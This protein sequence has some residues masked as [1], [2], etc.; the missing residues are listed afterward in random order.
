MAPINQG[1]TVADVDA[2]VEREMRCDA[3]GPAPDLD[4]KHFGSNPKVAEAAAAYSTPSW[5]RRNLPT[6][7][8]WETQLYRPLTVILN[9]V[10]KL[11]EPDERT[12]DIVWYDEHATNSDAQ[13]MADTRP[14]IAAVIQGGRTRWG[15]LHTLIQVKKKADTLPTV[16]GLLRFVYQALREQFDR[17]FMYGMVFSM[18]NLTVWHVD[19]SGALASEVFNI[20]EEP[21]RFIKVILSFIMLRP[22]ELGWDPTMKMYIEDVHEGKITR[23]YGLPSYTIKENEENG[24]SN[25]FE[26]MWIVSVPKPSAQPD[27]SR[28]GDAGAPPL[29]LSEEEEFVVFNAV[30][31]SGSEVVKGRATRIWKAWKMVDM[32]ISKEQRKVYIIKD[33]W[34]DERRGEEGA[35][36]VQAGVCPGVALYYSHGDVRIGERRNVDCTFKLV[37]KNVKAQ[38]KPLYLRTDQRDQASWSQDYFTALTGWEYPQYVPR[39]RIHMRLVMASHGHPLTKFSTLQELLGAL[40]DAIQ[41]HK[42]LYENG[43]LHRDIS[44]GNILITGLPA[45]NRGILIDLD[46]GINWP[47]HKT[48]ADGERMG[49]LAFMSYEILS[50]RRILSGTLAFP[51]TGPDGSILYSFFSKRDERMDMNLKDVTHDAVHDLESF[52]WVLCWLCVAREGPGRARHFNTDGL[53]EEQVAEAIQ[54][55]DTVVAAFEQKS[56]SG[57]ATRKHNILVEM[58][59]FTSTILNSF[60][61]YFEPLETLLCWLHGDLHRAYKNRNFEGLHGK[62]L[63]Y[64]TAAEQSPVIQGWEATDNAYQE[65]SEAVLKQRDEPETIWDSSKLERI[66]PSEK[67]PSVHKRSR[68]KRRR[69]DEELETIA[70]QCE[71]GSSSALSERRDTRSAA[72][73]RRRMASPSQAQ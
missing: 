64:L 61:P 4:E 51:P 31:L 5:R 6:N 62:F 45:P 50:N 14:D 18:Y 12:F 27:E 33:C 11:C 15:A 39:N 28:P 47:D 17:R 55:H 54:I 32:V 72:R 66:V 22:E 59:S 40:H 68:N 25:A 69:A 46:N 44:L 70:E 21:L 73:K 24:T 60:T 49:T 43:V 38:G 56:T 48:H 52:F 65:M 10:T 34:R 19:R 3:F 8:I 37:R 35:F 1:L 9:A 41:G 58:G 16:S 13:F 63:A 26:R 30:S 42:Y 23:R 2:A 67:P 7:P 53:S 36:Y 57:I 71:G 29:P 20:H